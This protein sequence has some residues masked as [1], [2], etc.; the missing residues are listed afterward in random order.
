MI[1]YLLA[2]YGNTMNIS[3]KGWCK[4]SKLAQ[5]WKEADIWFYP[6]TFMETFCLTALEAASSETLVV[7]NDLAALQNTVGNRGVIIPGDPL[8]AEWKKQALQRLLPFLLETEEAK[9]EKRQK[10]QANLDWAKT[11]TWEKQ[12]QR[13]QETIMNPLSLTQHCEYF[14]SFPFDFENNQ[15][16]LHYFNFEYTIQ[17]TFRFLSVLEVGTYTGVS[18]LKWMEKLQHAKGVGV[19]IWETQDEIPLMEALEVQSCFYANVEKN[20]L[21]HRIQGVKEDSHEY[22]M[23]CIVDNQ[24]YD[25]ILVDGQ[26]SESGRYMDLWLAWRIL[27][28]GGIILTPIF[29][30]QNLFRKIEAWNPLQKVRGVWLELKKPFSNPKET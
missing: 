29:P 8:H 6:C 7:T 2:D 25:L 23:R 16:L 3:V 21:Q 30:I 27:P 10:I 11:L 19:D 15:D 28:P 13:F 17:G 20:G 9:Q 12:A 4:K 5:A 24:K 26:S 1:R 18:L 14:S 22:L